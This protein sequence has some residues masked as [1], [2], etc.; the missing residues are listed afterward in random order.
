VLFPQGFLRVLAQITSRPCRN[1][2]LTWSRN[3]AA[4][5]PSATCAASV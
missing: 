2:M 1:L 4:R 3:S 5:Q